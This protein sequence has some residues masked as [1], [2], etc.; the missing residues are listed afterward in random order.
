MNGAPFA[1]A[2]AILALGIGIGRKSGSRSAA[3]PDVIV[4]FAKE[5]GEYKVVT[6]RSNMG[7]VQPIKIMQLVSDV[8]GGGSDVASLSVPA[9]SWAEAL[10]TMRA[11]GAARGVEV[12][13]SSHGEVELRRDTRPARGRAQA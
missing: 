13:Q 11:L 3:N 7:N 2:A 6:M 12:H 1:L 5:G 8:T 9:N 10:R 4:R